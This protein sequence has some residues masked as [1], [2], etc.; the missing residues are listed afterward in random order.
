VAHAS[1]EEPLGWPS[2]REKA[3]SSNTFPVRCWKHR[4]V[5]RVVEG[6]SSGTLA[7]NQFS[8]ST[9]TDR[10]TSHRYGLDFGHDSVMRIQPQ[11]KAYSVRSQEPSLLSN[12]PFAV[13][14]KGGRLGAGF[15][16]RRD[17]ALRASHPAVSFHLNDNP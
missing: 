6:R 8:L 5:A 7:M 1:D 11:P 15:G 4:V 10:C 14:A 2:I 17:D 16:K 3:L 9:P 12:Q 13:F